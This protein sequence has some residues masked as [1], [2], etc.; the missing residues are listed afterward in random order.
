MTPTHKLL[1]GGVPVY[2]KRE[3]LYQPPIPMTYTGTVGSKPPPFAKT[4]GLLPYLQDL[5]KNGIETVAYMDTT[6]SM[7]S[8]GVAYCAPLAGLKAVVFFP[9]Y[10]DGIPRHNTEEH[11]KR[12]T[13]LGAEVLPLK[14]PTQM[15]V[16]W[17][18]ARRIIH[19]KYPNAQL[20]P[21]GLPFKETVTSVAGEIY[22]V[23]GPALGGTIV[24]AVGSGTML[25]GIIT[26]LTLMKEPQHIHGVLVSPG[27]LKEMKIKITNHAYGR[28]ML[29]H[30]WQQWLTLVD[31]K[32]EYQDAVEMDIPFP[33]NKYYDAKAWKYLVDHITDL[34]PPILFWNIGA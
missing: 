33:C 31:E 24:V 22:N 17:Y 10:K 9:E 34:Q 28:L 19:E 2:V 32:Y 6:I 4:R 8:W 12:C 26:G 18:R 13:E 21:Q 23:P 29:G 3:D 15:S 7:A 1:V 25:S 30:Y 27:N 16:N 11:I 14:T 5:R 20:L